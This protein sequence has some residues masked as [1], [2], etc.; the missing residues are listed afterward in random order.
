M[1]AS[2]VCATEKSTF[3]AV[4]GSGEQVTTEKKPSVPQVASAEPEYPV[5]QITAT[6]PPV[7][8]WISSSVS[9]L[10]LATWVDSQAFAV[11]VTRENSP[12]V[13]HSASPPPL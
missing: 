11:Q 8:P 1:E 12:R 13:V 2:L 4:Q 3:V 7:T 9:L 5:S 10:E 6:T